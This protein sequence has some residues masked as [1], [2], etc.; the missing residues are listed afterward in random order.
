MRV[1]D[2]DLPP[3]DR[4][5]DREMLLWEREALLLGI[6]EGKPVERLDRVPRRRQVEVAP[7][8]L[9]VNR[10]RRGGGKGGVGYG[11]T[12]YGA[13]IMSIVLATK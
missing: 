13:A 5:A 8:D 1:V 12:G 9:R 3:G 4:H 2:A 11:G 7:P 10:P 6:L